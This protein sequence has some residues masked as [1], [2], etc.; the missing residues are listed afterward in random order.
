MYS[1]YYAQF[2]CQ[3]LVNGTR[4]IRGRSHGGRK[5]LAREDPTRRNN[6]TLG[7]RAEI[8]V[9]VMPQK[10]RLE[11]ELELVG[12]EKKMQFGPFCSLYWR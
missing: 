6:F 8:S 11:K 7:L 12:D 3:K 10:R 2:A 9:R 4:T 1:L 5:I